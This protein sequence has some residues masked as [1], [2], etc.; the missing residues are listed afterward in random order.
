MNPL[1]TVSEACHVLSTLGL[2]LTE[3]QVRYLGLTP[4]HRAGGHNGGR[5]F[6][7]VDVTLLAVFAE[8]LERCRRWGLPVWSARAGLLYRE[9]ELRRAIRRGAPRHVVVDALRG[10]VTLSET[11]DE[12]AT[13]IDLRKRARQVRDAARSYR[14]LEPDVWT[15]AERVSLEDL[16]VA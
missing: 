3:R 11:A 4:A 1:L 14:E 6:D 15:G 16:T 5:L 12:P 7:P 8:L 10:T 13:A 2:A 9:T